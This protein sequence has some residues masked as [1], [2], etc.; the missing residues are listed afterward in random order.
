MNLWWW[1]KRTYQ[2]TDLEIDLLC[3]LSFRMFLTSQGIRLSDE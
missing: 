1:H 3:K 2:K